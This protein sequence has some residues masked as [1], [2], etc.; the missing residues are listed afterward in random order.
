LQLEQKNKNHQGACMCCKS[1]LV[2]ARTWVG[3][4]LRRLLACPALGLAMLMSS[5]AVPAHAQNSAE[6]Q[7]GLT[8][9]QAQGQSDGPLSGEVISM[10]T[11]VQTRFEAVLTCNLIIE[12]CMERLSLAASSSSIHKN[13]FV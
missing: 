1:W 6:V 5:L 4:F 12:A 8:W 10:D 13:N 11:P 9:L 7:R 2:I 3:D